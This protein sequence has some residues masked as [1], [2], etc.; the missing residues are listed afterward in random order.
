MRKWGHTWNMLGRFA[1]TEVDG[2][3]NWS[4]AYASARAKGQIIIT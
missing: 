1:R 2:E 4:M 3:Q